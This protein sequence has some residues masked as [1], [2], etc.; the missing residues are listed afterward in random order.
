MILGKLNSDDSS[1]KSIFEIK[2]K[3]LIID[4]C[5]IDYLMLF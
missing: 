4:N 3:Y 1:A 2:L 5:V